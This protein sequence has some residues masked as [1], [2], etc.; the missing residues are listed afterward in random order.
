MGARHRLYQAPDEL[1]RQVLEAF[2]LQRVYDK[3]SRGIQISATITETIA[4]N[5]ENAKE[6][7]P[8]D[9]VPTARAAEHLLDLC[10]RALEDLP[11][12]RRIRQD[13]PSSEQMLNW[14]GSG[15]LGHLSWTFNS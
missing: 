1:K 3:P 8:E 9:L 4:D 12:I 2:G 15:C 7:S 13:C 5:L 6:R 14:I 10:T 11:L